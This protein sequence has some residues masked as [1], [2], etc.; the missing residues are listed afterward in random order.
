MKCSLAVS[1]IDLAMASVSSQND[2]LASITLNRMPS[3]FP[4]WYPVGGQLHEGGAFFRVWANTHDDVSVRVKNQTHRLKAEVDGFFSGFVA[5]LREGDTYSYFLDGEGPFA[6]LASRFQPEGP[7]GPAAL[8]NPDRF[9]WTDQNWQGLKLP[10]QVIYELHIG[11]FT[12]EGNWCS[13][14]EQL[15]ELAKLGIT[16]LEVMP[17][18]DYSGAFGWGY[19]GVNLFAP[20]RNYGMPDDFR[21]FVNAAHGLG[22]GVL[23]DVVY[24]HIGPDGNYFAKFS[25]DYFT[26][27]HTTE[28]GEAINFYGQNNA[29]VRQFFVGN[30]SYWIK[31]FHLDGL[32]LDAT[33]SIFDKSSPH[34]LTE[35]ARGARRAAEPRSVIIVAENEP[36]DTKLI[37]TEAEGGYGLDGLWN[38]DFHHSWFVATTGSREAY[39]MDY[40]GTPQELISSLKYG[41]LFQGQWYAWQKKRRGTSTLGTDPA[42]MVAYI[43]NHDQI[44]NSGRGLRLHELTSKGRYKAATAVCLLGPATPFLFQGQEFA[45][46]APFLFFADH[47]HK[48]AELVRKGRAEFLHQW[49]SLATGQLQFDDPSSQATFEK[50]KLDFS[51]R[52]KHAEFYALHRDLLELR[53]RDPLFSRQTRQFDGAVLGPEAFV[54]RFFSETFRD[55]RLLIVNLGT[56]LFLSPSPE[57]LLGPPENAA[58]EIMWSSEDPKYGGNGTPAPDSERN[59]IIPGHAAV[60]MKPVQKKEVPRSDG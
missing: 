30:A 18:A 5:D 47:E 57:P 54:L 55:D 45:S 38:D 26:A 10:H 25:K 13:A 8:V 1:P 51:E 46:S 39:L 29:P 60:V 42:A 32:R 33:Q 37:R 56:Q 44:S 59:W 11:T 43:Q 14:I 7:H 34:I 22:M 17:V 24:N 20:T 6:D 3:S 41:Y 28:W 50:C 4:W 53:K 23:L 16:A 15:A 40:L 31:E 12:R 27:D 48:L 2:A 49:R 19:D 36:Q 52:A 9:V 58:W 21:A 35:I